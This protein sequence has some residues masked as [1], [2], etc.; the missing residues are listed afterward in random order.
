MRELVGRFDAVFDVYLKTSRFLLNWNAIAMFCIML[1]ANSYNIFM[2]T[3]FERGTIWHQEVS[4]MAAFWI[5][6]AAYGLLSKEDSFIRVEFVV[7]QFPP[8]VQR[9]ILVLGRLV[10]IAFHIILFII[11]INLF[12]VI[13]IYE[14]AILQWPEYVFYIPLTVGTF[15]IVV[16]EVIHLLRT[17]A[18]PE[19]P[20]VDATPPPIFE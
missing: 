1:G 5:Y 11:C 18:F 17:L 13:A 4:I 12:D 14:T 9:S 16:T 8:G 7:E 19:R 6:F 2:R 3:V 20:P 10:V 15:D